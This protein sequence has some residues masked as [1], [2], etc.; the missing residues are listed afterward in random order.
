MSTEIKTFKKATK[1]EFERMTVNQRKEY[2]NAFHDFIY[3]ENK[4]LKDKSAVQNQ[5][6]GDK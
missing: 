1:R 4:N 5:I 3:D 6:R 2:L